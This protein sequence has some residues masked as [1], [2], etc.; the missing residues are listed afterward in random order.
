[1]KVTQGGELSLLEIQQKKKHLRREFKAKL[2]VALVTE[3]T[4]LSKT[5][6]ESCKAFFVNTNHQND[7]GAY[8][9]LGLEAD[10]QFSQMPGRFA[11]PVVQGDDLVFCSVS[12]QEDFVSGSFG[13]L[14]PNL[15][16]CL[17]IDKN[18]LEGVFVPALA[19]DRNGG[20]LGKGKGYYDRFLKNFNGMKVGLAYSVQISEELLPVDTNDVPVN[21]IVTEKEVI[22]CEV[23][24]V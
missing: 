14:E 21:W 9:P 10:P 1:M 7:W 17:P 13:V 22:R 12:S 3:A 20:R 15:K 5:L 18:D 11:Y 16:T 24:H 8:M 19:F 2:E 6:R 4:I 23:N